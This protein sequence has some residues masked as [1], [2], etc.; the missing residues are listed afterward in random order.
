MQQQS[1]QPNST[2]ATGAVNGSSGSNSSSLS[3]PYHAQKNRAKLA[4]ERMR[5]NRNK[6]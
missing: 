1:Q 2:T 4:M 3:S 6:K 5:A